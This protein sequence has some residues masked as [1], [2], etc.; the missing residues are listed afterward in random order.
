MI[1]QV[2]IALVMLAS[3]IVAFAQRNLIYSALLLI[4]TWAGFAAFYLFT[5]AEFI[6]FA[7]L[8]IYVGAVS[9]VVLFAVL[10]TRRSTADPLEAPALRRH[11]LPAIT[12]GLAVAVVLGL[13][14]L[15]TPFPS[16][17]AQ[18]PQLSVR[19][20]GHELMGGYTTSLLIA[21]VILTVA[22]I[23][24]TIL[25]AAESAHGTSRIDRRI[26]GAAA[27]SPRASDETRRGRRDSREIPNPS[28]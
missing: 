9:M 17:P 6:A 3:A 1:A 23:G 16:G 19:Q 7:Q 11:K 10:L 12:A 21:G 20:I 18:A 25:A 14:V 22:L 28:P 24:A 8:L 26:A 27:P 15:N 5:G 4:L 13:A 2:L